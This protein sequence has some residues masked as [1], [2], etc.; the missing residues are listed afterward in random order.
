MHDLALARNEVHFSIIF[1][2][3]QFYEVL[4]MGM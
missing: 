1:Q 4:L 3:F 2:V